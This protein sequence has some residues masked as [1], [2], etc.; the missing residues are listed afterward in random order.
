MGAW[1]GFGLKIRGDLL[2]GVVMELYLLGKEWNIGV[3]LV[4]ERKKV[5]EGQCIHGWKEWF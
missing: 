1:G 4:K 5:G 2:E 3:E